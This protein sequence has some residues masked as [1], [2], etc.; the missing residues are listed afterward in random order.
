[1]INDPSTHVPAVE[2]TVGGD[3]PPV[4][5]NEV[6]RLRS[7]TDSGRT[8]RAVVARKRMWVS[9]IRYSGVFGIAL[10]V[11]GFSLYLP[12]LFFSQ[13]TFRTIISAQAITGI[14]ALGALIPLAAGL[15]D[16]SF[17]S[18]G[19]LAIV[20]TVWMTVHTSY[21]YPLIMLISIGSA[22]TCGLVSGLLVALIKLDSFIVTLGMSSLVLGISELIT[23]GNTL[24]GTFSPDVV[25]FSQGSL[26]PVPYLTLVLAAL[27]AVVWV[28]LEHTPS[29][30]YTLAVGSNPLAARLAGIAV[31]RT[32]IAALVA[33]AAVAGLGGTLLAA[34]VGSGSTTTGPGYLLP[35]IAA[36]FL[37]ETQVRERPNVVGTLIAIFLLGTGIKGLQL[38]GASTWTT[39]AFNGAVLLL[40]VG[41]AAVR[42]RQ[43][44]VGS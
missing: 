20:L 25:S 41:M 12:G 9:A 21:P 24:F 22:A 30:R 23:G 39:D 14:L 43:A 18:I 28:W 11:V 27:A 4:R 5:H 40:A 34:Q 1:M 16:L 36:L 29:G 8:R 26:G 7:R 3:A 44:A 42:R 17:G 2:L 38:A 32:Q 37:G 13:V 15:I 31:A 10:L 33:S 35:V 19:G 6:N